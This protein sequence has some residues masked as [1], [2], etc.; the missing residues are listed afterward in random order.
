V[1]RT[2]GL[3]VAVSAML[4]S[5]FS[6]NRKL[7]EQV[8]YEGPQFKVKLST[9]YE[10]VYA[11]LIDDRYYT[12]RVQCAPARGPWVDISGGS[13]AKE[14]ARSIAARM[15]S[16]FIAADER[17]LIWKAGALIAS[18]DACNSVV[19]WSPVSLPPEAI[20]QTPKPDY[21]SAPRV[22]CRMYDFMNDRAPQYENVRLERPGMLSF[23]VRSKALRNDFL[24]ST[25]DYGKTW[26]ATPTSSPTAP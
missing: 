6:I 1:T 24:V 25:K 2:L 22:D 21:C 8:F 13:F 15:K 9:H 26:S 19:Y 18:F 12:Y 17:T 11:V 20:D 23:H 4:T 5:C 3:L 16:N 14:S 10:R 7:D